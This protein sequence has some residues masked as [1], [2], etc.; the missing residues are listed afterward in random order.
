MCGGINGT[1]LSLVKAAQW[2]KSLDRIM[3]QKVMRTS[4]WWMIVL[5]AL[6]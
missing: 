1:L 5:V 6:Y 2:V 3:Q 4:A